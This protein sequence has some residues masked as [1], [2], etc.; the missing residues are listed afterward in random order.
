MCG[1]HRSGTTLLRN[2]LD[3]H[4]VVLTLP[5]DGKGH[6]WVR[7]I[8]KRPSD[9]RDQEVAKDILSQLICPNYEKPPQW[10]LARQR[11]ELAPYLHLARLLAGW[12]RDAGADPKAM[13]LAI[14]GSYYASL[15]DGARAGK[16]YWAE[17][18]TSNLFRTDEL[19]RMFPRARFVCIV[20]HPAGVIC[21]QKRR[22]QF[23][24]RKFDIFRELE[25]LRQVLSRA[26]QNV[27]ELGKGRFHVVRYEDLV[28]NK[29][30]ELKK[31]CAFL[32]IPVEGISKN[33]T[34][35]GYPA[36]P[37]TV[38]SVGTEELGR[39]SNSSANLWRKTL[40]AEEITLVETCLGGAMAPFGYHCDVPSFWT[41]LSAVRKLGSA[42]RGTDLAARPRVSAFMRYWFRERWATNV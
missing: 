20:R 1:A 7:R 8:A 11:M 18:T 6:D 10:V 22:Q 15:D 16:R 36:S 13:L 40:S 26:Q 33:P 31:I 12:Q 9:A 42:D 32:H 24:Q 19:C 41:G 17:K 38:Y 3:G 29:E 28:D 34:V 4:S 23:K 2:L 39:I 27:Q 35:N 5:L 25:Y 30:F 37:N 21:S 14:L